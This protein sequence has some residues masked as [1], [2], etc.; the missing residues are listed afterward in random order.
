MG[1]L[2]KNLTQVLSESCET[3]IDEFE[4]FEDEEIL[5]ELEEL[6]ELEEAIC[7]TAEMVNV[8]AQE[9][10]YGSRYLVEYDNLNKLMESYGVDEVEALNMVCEHNLLNMADIYVVIE[11]VDY[12]KEMLNEAKCGKGPAKSK[13][14]KKLANCSKAI[15]NLKNKGIKMV[16][17]KRK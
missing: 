16:T 7:Y 13:K 6:E 15:K 5:D 11:S 10:S 1:L 14:S 2:F 9:T 4:D 3:E 8:I 12:V 17:K